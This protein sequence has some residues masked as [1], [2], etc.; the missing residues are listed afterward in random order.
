MSRWLPAILDQRIR[1]VRSRKHGLQ[2]VG[3]VKIIDRKDYCRKKM[4][5]LT[6]L[7]SKSR[8]LPENKKIRHTQWIQEYELDIDKSFR[9]SDERGGDKKL[10][11]WC[12]KRP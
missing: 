6:K 5:R 2:V 12:R 4:W 8:N 9:T 3:Q 1:G 11:I 7:F 10:K